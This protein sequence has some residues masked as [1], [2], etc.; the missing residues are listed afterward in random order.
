VVAISL[1]KKMPAHRDSAQL[2]LDLI[3]TD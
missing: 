1:K 2:R 3:G